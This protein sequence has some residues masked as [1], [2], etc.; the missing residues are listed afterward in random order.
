MS[1]RGADGLPYL[2]R[3]FPVV[4]GTIAYGRNAMPSELAHTKGNE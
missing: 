1:L 3:V 4:N 2:A